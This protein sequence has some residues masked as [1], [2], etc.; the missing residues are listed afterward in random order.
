MLHNTIQSKLNAE[1]ENPDGIHGGNHT[2]CFG[3]P[4]IELATPLMFYQ[5]KRGYITIERLIDAMLRRPAR[6]MGLRVGAQTQVTW[7]MSEYRIGEAKVQSHS[8]FTGSL[9]RQIGNRLH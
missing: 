6:I 8:G 5:V 1:L 2:T 7:D 9:P 3:V 4:G